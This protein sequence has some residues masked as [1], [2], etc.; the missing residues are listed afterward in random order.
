MNNYFICDNCGKKVSTTGNI[1]THQ[2]NHCPYCLYS[3]HVDE[4]PGDRKAECHGLMKPVGLTFKREGE[5][6]T[7]EIMLVHICERCGKISINRL[8]GDDDVTKV[9]QVYEESFGLDE[10]LKEKIKVQNISLVEEKDKKEVMTQL[11]GRE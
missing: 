9:Q 8:A 10:S 4:F 5:G 6:K 1:G 2:R 3:K 11:V 7:G